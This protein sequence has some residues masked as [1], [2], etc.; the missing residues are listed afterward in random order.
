MMMRT[1]IKLLLVLLLYSSSSFAQPNPE[2]LN[3]DYLVMSR[4]TTSA[5]RLKSSAM[6]LSIGKDFSKFYWVPLQEH[7]KYNMSI[8][9]YDVYT[10]YK[11]YPDKT[12]LTFCGEV[13]KVPYAY[14]E[15]LPDFGWEMQEGDTI[16]CGY[17]CQKATTT[18]R[19]VT[20]TAWFAVDLPYSDG[21]WKLC[22]LPGL[23]LRAYDSRC[24]YFF[25]A[26]E[27]KKGDGR[28]IKTDLKHSKKSS[29]EEY[30]KEMIAYGKEPDQYKAN[31]GVMRKVMVY[32]ENGNEVESHTA[33]W[34]PN[35]FEYFEDGE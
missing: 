28:E 13:I 22:G 2:V 4:E 12:Q 33:P 29:P 16:V 21:P 31:H 25:T 32:D 27:V 20:W 6:M 17:N 23:I 3:V 1:Y 5:P 9:G 35:L 10:V 24:N 11:G 26:V 7:R 19:G 30:A 34:T 18:F 14:S 8:I 15:P